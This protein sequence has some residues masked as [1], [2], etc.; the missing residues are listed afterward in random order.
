[1]STPK[2]AF[3]PE[4]VRIKLADLV[5][6][7]L[8]D[9]IETSVSRYSAILASI[10]ETGVVEPLVVY[11]MKGSKGK[12]II[13]DGN[14]RYH[15][16]ARSGATEASCILS[17]E[18]ES[19]TY[20]YRIN[21]L[22]PIQEHYM[23]A[24]AVRLG[25]KVERIASALTVSVEQ[26]QDIL[27]LLRGLHPEAVALLETRKIRHAAIGVL[28]RVK[29][30]RQIEMAE[31]M[32]MANNFSSTYAHALLSATPEELIIE[33]E[34]TYR[35]HHTI[36]EEDEARLREEMRQLESD[37]RGAEETYGDNLLK[38]TTAKGYLRSLLGNARVVRWLTQR[39]R[40]ILNQFEEIVASEAL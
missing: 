13:V 23:M 31:L 17:T 14:L 18:N 40:E 28:K 38:L 22:A 25:V 7:R 12:Y 15:A 26:I 16:L 5:P 6:I 21:R 9:K 20:N 33:K 32:V 39:H 37:F 27:D 11:P 10:S 34:R 2:L 24:R 30:V 3:T 19:F 35:L 8:P 1:M 29:P 36:S 4:Q